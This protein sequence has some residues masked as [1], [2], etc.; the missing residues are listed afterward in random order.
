MRG[1][2]TLWI[3][4]GFSTAR[5]EDNYADVELVPVSVIPLHRVVS[6]GWGICKISYASKV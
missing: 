6:C 3:F 1:L 4:S 5:T 2:V